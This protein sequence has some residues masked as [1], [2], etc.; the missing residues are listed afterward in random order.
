LRTLI[1]NLLLDLGTPIH[2]LVAWV[3]NG[4]GISSQLQQDSELK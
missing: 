4:R 1:A 2:V 3:Q